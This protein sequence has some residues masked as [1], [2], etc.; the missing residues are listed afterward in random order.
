MTLTELAE[1]NIV[2]DSE[3]GLAFMCGMFYF[4][5]DFNIAKYPKD[6]TMYSAGKVAE[7]TVR[8]F[9]QPSSILFKFLI[10][11]NFRATAK[12]DNN[13]IESEEE[14]VLAPAGITILTFLL[15][16][17]LIIFIEESKVKTLCNNRSLNNE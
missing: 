13:Y 3:R 10:S 4:L 2:R 1:Q 15:K 12:I 11:E 6:S 8:N 7:F 9:E 16:T 5:E 17:I 14:Q